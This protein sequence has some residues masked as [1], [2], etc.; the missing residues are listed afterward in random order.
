MEYVIDSLR[1]DWEAFL[2]FSPRLLYG[3]V[4]LAVF[5]VIG[6]LSG[7]LAGSVL[8]EPAPFISLRGFAASYVD[9]EI[10]FWLDTNRS[11]RGCVAIVNNV[12]IHC[13]RALR[14]AGMTFSTDVTTGLELKSLPAV[15]VSIAGGRPESRETT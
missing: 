5:A 11:K 14:D 9:Y 4:V 13:W 12:K 1:A 10:Y 2:R 15:D 6:R 3:L 7:R 8:A